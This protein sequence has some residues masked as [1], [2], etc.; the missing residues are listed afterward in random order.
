MPL[1]FDNADEM[2]KLKEA[3]SPRE[4]KI[5]VDEPSAILRTSET[6]AGIQR[7]SCPQNLSTQLLNKNWEIR[8][9]SPPSTASCNQGFITL[10]ER[11]M[12]S[13]VY[14]SLA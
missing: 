9:A 5:Y 1:T 2:S 14:G 6:D 11:Q 7:G 8:S 10:I 12:W 4:P 3:F 13:R